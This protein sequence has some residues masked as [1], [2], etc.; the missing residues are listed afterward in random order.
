MDNNQVTCGIFI[1]L[2]KTFDAVN[3][4]ILIDKIENLGI[5]RKAQELFISYLSDREQYVNMDN[6]K[7][8]TRPIRCGFPKAR[9]LVPYSFYSSLRERSHIT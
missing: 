3:P 6:C 9:S 7:S 5:R 1:D 8:K 4:N 2:S